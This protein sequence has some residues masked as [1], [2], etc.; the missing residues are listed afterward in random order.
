MPRGDP[1]TQFCQQVAHAGRTVAADLHLH[2]T[3]SDG[4]FTPSHA[5]ALASVA[6][7]KSIALTDHDTFAGLA[8]ARE[9]AT[10]FPVPRRPEIIA[11][12]EIS[13]EFEGREVH[14][15]GLFVDPEN[16]PLLGALAK[17]AASRV[18][19]FRHCIDHFARSGTPID[20]GRVNAVLAGTACP[21][22]RHLAG[23]LVESGFA[24][25]RYDAF[26]RFLNPAL[27][28]ISPKALIPTDEAIRLIHAAGG[29]ASLAHPASDY[30]SAAFWRFGDLGLRAV[31]AEYPAATVG[32][33][34][35]LRAWA[36]DLG[37]AITGGSDC[38]GADNPGRTIGSRGVTA[39]ELETLRGWCG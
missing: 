28:S 29:I 5:V 12:V 25:S 11:G 37:W 30:D 1:F 16:A 4:D 38:H 9:A 32:R 18:V 6:N 7:L 33:T 10:Q 2:S 8:A 22:R 34:Q 36:K 20:E 3:A 14:I 27:S 35:E 39:A 15:L 24:R 17:I 31:E 26:T 13:A 23:L 19:R 21:G